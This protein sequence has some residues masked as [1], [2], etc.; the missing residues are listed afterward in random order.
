[1]D[2]GGDRVTTMLLNVPTSVWQ[3][4]SV[5]AIDDLSACMIP[6]IRKST[7][8][9]IVPGFDLWDLWP[10]QLVTGQT[11]DF[12][13]WTIWFIL[14]APS[15][16]DPESRHG[17]ARIRMVMEK[18]GVWKDCGNLFPDDANPGSREWAGSA[19]YD[20]ATQRMTH[21]FT[22]AGM[23]GEEK[24]TVAQRL[25]HLSADLAVVGGTA[26]SKA[27]TI[28]VETVR[29]DGF[30]Y[31]VVDQVEGVPGKIKGFRDPSHFRD[32]ATGVDY[33]YFTGSQQGS[34][35]DWNGVIGVAQSTSGFHDGWELLP[36]VFS[37]V[38]LNNELERPIMIERDGSYYLFWSTQ[39]KVFADNG[40]SGPNGLYGVVGSSPTGP[41]V[42]LNGTG[43]VAANPEDAPFQAYSWW[44]TSDLTVHGFADLIAVQ[45]AS[46]VVDTPDWRRQHFGG[47]PAPVFRIWLDGDRA[48]V[49][50]ENA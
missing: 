22:A 20:P 50:R 16:L 40:P 4:A 8:P 15:E 9:Q 25:F 39:R 26:F 10:L 19:L 38:G 23:K 37:A 32:P 14:S 7:V 28:P 43:L 5:A 47:V 24:P 21:F 27:W 36:P 11:A 44:V 49:V 13:G 30:H 3:P 6:H 35:S 12:S 33:L 31:V 1:M 2:M 42:P 34:K 29:S 45:S 17:R 41:F 48:G 46:D 18:D